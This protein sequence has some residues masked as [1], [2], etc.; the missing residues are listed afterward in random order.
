VRAHGPIPFRGTQLLVKGQLVSIDQGNRTERVVIGLGAGR[1]DVQTHVQVF[2]DRAGDDQ[3]IE[4]LDISA[5][6]S[7]KPGAAET[8]GVGALA[9]DLVVSGAITVAG[10]V[11]SESFGG[12]VEADARRTA[13]KVV[14]E[15]EAFFDRQGWIASD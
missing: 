8:L 13:G 1:S 14:D 11:A 5:K 12:T 15:L 10:T 6:G 4:Q 9:G 3:D 7:R 2:L